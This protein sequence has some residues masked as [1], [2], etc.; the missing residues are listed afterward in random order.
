M[1]K[2]KEVGRPRKIKACLLGTHKISVVRL[3]HFL[4]EDYLVMFSDLAKIDFQRRLGKDGI[5]ICVFPTI[6]VPCILMVSK[7][8]ESKRNARKVTTKYAFMCYE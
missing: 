2:K 8:T 7:P 6:L 4:D 3:K 1:Q 5:G